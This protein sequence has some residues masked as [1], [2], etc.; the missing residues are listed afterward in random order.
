VEVRLGVAHLD[1]AVMRREVDKLHNKVE[2]LDQQLLQFSSGAEV[3]S[4]NQATEGQAELKTQV[5]ALTE[6]LQKLETEKD[7]YETLR[8]ESLLW[9]GKLEKVLE[10]MNIL[11]VDKEHSRSQVSQLESAG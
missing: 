4:S 8:R 9:E 6:L 7:Q 1:K 2:I 11:S 5:G 3:T 10:E